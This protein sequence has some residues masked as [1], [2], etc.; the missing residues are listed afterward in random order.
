[1]NDAFGLGP[2]GAWAEVAGS[3]GNAHYRYE[4]NNSRYYT[5]GIITI[6]ATGKVGDAARS[7][8]AD[9]KQSG[10]VDYV[11]FTD[12][13]TN[14]PYDPD[15]DCYRYAYNSRPSTCGYIQFGAG[16]VID[17]P[18]HSNDRIRIE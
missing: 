18:V 12:V 4:V 6:R 2:T 3:D 15:S 16:D 7:L 11:Y 9:L 10:F 8:V 14:D 13:E 17:G 1:T 5:D